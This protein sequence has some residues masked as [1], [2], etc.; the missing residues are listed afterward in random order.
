MTRRDETV[1]LCERGKHLLAK[2]EVD[3]SGPHLDV[4]QLVYHG[5]G[6]E[7]Q[8]VRYGPESIRTDQAGATLDVGCACGRQYM[9]NLV[10][11]FR[12]GKIGT[13]TRMRPE[14]NMYGTSDDRRRSAVRKSDQ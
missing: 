12:E 8:P 14:E 10:T 11:A 5:D 4:R 13:V 9:I 6:F 3:S 2:F 7:I 1:A